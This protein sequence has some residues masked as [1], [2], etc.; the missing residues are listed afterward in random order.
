MKHLNPNLDNIINAEIAAAQ[1]A[2]STIGS[3]GVITTAMG[4]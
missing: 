4:E 3:V 2:T 1:D